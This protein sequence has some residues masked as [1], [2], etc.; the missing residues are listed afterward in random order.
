MGFGILFML[1]VLHNIANLINDISE[2]LNMRK[3][4]MHL[5]MRMGRKASRKEGLQYLEKMGYFCLIQ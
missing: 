4:K 3:M 2:G 5:D 1:V